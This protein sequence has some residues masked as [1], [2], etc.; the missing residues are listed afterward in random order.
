MLRFIILV[1]ILSLIFRR[2]GM[3]YWGGPFMGGFGMGFRRRHPM[4]G[5]H[6]GPGPMGFGG[7]RGPH[8]RF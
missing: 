4:G 6:H 2:P 1:G 7:H 5:F 3:G 8:G